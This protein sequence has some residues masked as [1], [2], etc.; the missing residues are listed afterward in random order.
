MK[1][2]GKV[3]ATTLSDSDSSNSD[4]YESC[5][6]KGNFSAFMN[7]AHVESSDD[8][9]M[10][11]G[12]LGE[13][14]KLESIGILEETDDEEDEE[15]MGLQ[16]TYNSLLEK[17]GEYAKVAKVAIKKMKRVEKD[18][19]SLL[20]RYKEAKCEIETLNG[21]LIEAYTKVKFLKLEVVRANAKVEKVS[22]KKLDDVLSQQ[23]P[24]FDKSGLGYTGESNSAANLSKEVKF[25]KTKELMVAAKNAEK[26]KPE[27]KNNVTDQRFM[28]KPP[29]QSVVKP[30]RNGKSLPK[31][32][33]GLR[34]QYFCHHYGI[35]VHTRPNCHKLQALKNSGAQRPRGPR[36]DKRT[37]AIEQS[38]GRDG[39]SGVMD[40]IKL[41]G[42]FT[43]C[44]ESF[45]RRFES[46]NSCTQ[47]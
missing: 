10:L 47:S 21:E 20:V 9:S 16:E 43:I 45:T 13:H 29:K 28:T 40:V 30:K 32:Q 26:V 18:Y 23:K 1:A 34:T 27:K 36:N 14:P 37:W 33:R 15:A 6:R 44:L 25:V 7:I 4:S 17:T 11:V 42:A 12:E 35:Q 19:R 46:P 24:F 5:D 38:R 2:K 41:I 39:D 8:L 31:S 22:T 3:Y